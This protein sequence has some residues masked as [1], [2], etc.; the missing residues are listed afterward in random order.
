MQK[1][2]NCQ[3]FNT[4]VEPPDLLEVV[5]ADHKLPGMVLFP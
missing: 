4:Y 1:V 2:Q 5:V 3:W